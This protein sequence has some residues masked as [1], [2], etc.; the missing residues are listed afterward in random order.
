MFRINGGQGV[1]MGTFPLLSGEKLMATVQ[2][3]GVSADGKAGVSRLAAAGMIIL[4]PVFGLLFMCLL[5][6]MSLL[7]VVTFMSRVAYAADAMK[8]DDAAMCMGCHAAKGLEKTFQNREKL[9]VSID[10]GHFRDSAHGFLTCTGCHSGISMDKHPSGQ[11]YASK[12]DFALQVSKACK[13]CHRDEQVLAKPIHRLAVTRAN[14]PPC[15]DC[16]GSHSIRKVRGWKETAGN[17]RYCLTCHKNDLSISL[18]GETLSLSIDESTLRRSVH[19][20]HDCAKCHEAFSKKDHPLHA[21]K[22]KRELSISLSGACKSCHHDKYQLMQGSIH[23]SM[24]AGGNRRAPVCTDCHGAHSVGPKAMA[25]TLAGVPCKK[26]HEAT[27]EAYKTSV[28][29]Q[30]KMHGNVSAPICSSCHSAHGMMPA[31]AS[32]SPKAT[33]FGCHKDAPALHKEWLPNAEAHLEAI[34]CTVCHVPDADRTVYLRI[35]DNKSGE[36]VTKTRVKEFLGLSYDDLA[37]VQENG[38]EGQQLW[39]IYQKL[40]AQKDVAGLTGTLGLKDCNQSHM[41]A[42][43]TKAVRQC[44]SCHDANSTFFS[45]VSMAIINPNGHEEHYR[46]NRAVLG[47]VFTVLPINQFY[48]LGGTRIRLLDI[49]GVLMVVGGM[50][51]PIVHI[52]L[53]IVTSPIRYAKSL[54]KLR[55]EQRQ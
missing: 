34:A 25:E 44:D 4:G 40:G 50:S 17:N 24:L 23:A 46:V 54:N 26:C 47:S 19:S 36:S 7:I 15:S 51:V 13:G 14:A 53:R 49:L 28:H 10:A 37:R 21:F 31:L 5:P 27:F 30:A 52:T 8:T 45:R 29:G 11:Q 43:K 2:A 48:V 32:R 9:S 22:N 20:K 55:K 1:K 6:L 41:L 35:T 33:C 3:A 12:M 18:N 39:D 38:I 16:H 42:P